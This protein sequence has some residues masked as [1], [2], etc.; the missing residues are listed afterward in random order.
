MRILIVFLLLIGPVLAGPLTD[1]SQCR[2]V[3]QNM[4]RSGAFSKEVIHQEKWRC[5]WYT[6]AAKDAKKNSWDKKESLKLKRA[7]N[8]L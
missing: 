4:E 7:F 3:I 1:P 5:Y 2:I 8:R 6:R